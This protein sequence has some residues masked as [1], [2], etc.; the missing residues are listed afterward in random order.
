M[1]T[2]NDSTLTSR[3]QRRTRKQKTKI[4]AGHFLVLVVVL[5]ALLG[6]GAYCYR[7]YFTSTPEYR[8]GQAFD[9]IEKAD[10][11]LAKI[12]AVIDSE[13]IE[14][15]PKEIGALR[16]D[17]EPTRDLLR[18]AAEYI[19]LAQDHAGESETTRLENIRRSIALRGNLLGLIPELLD[20]TEKSAIALEGVN[21]GWTYLKEATKASAAATEAF[22]MKDKAGMLESVKQNNEALTALAKA[23]VEFNDAERALEG[24]DFADYIAYIDIREQMAEAAI[25]AANDWTSDDKTA[26]KIDVQTYSKL[27]AKAQDMEE[28]TLVSP[29]DIV[30][31]TYQTLVGEQNTEYLD[32]RDQVRALDSLVR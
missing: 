22:D 9:Y 7:T 27:L 4:T 23:R 18:E 21:K 31:S 13:I 25:K 20:V 30:A 17:I 2:A 10:E 14:V 11:K 15:Q 5:A 24:L 26:L 16:N 28:N 32:I 12:N 19:R 1:S 29:T 8:I 3:S 6:V